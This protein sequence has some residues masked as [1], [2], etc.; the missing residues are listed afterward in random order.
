MNGFN[1]KNIRESLQFFMWTREEVYIEY[2]NFNQFLIDKEHLLNEKA[3]ILT[4][5]Q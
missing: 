4:G 1:T 3:L 2:I 5:E